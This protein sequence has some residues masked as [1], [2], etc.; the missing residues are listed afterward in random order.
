MKNK[1]IKTHL[2]G[3]GIIIKSFPGADG[4]QTYLA[5]FSGYG[6][7]FVRPKDLTEENDLLSKFSMN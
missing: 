4:V 5:S 6:R 7:Q 2:Y 1:S 3:P